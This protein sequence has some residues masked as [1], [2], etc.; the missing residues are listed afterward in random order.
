[1]FVSVGPFD[2]ILENPSSFKPYSYM[3]GNLEFSTDKTH[4]DYDA[5]SKGFLQRLRETLPIMPEFKVPGN[6]IRIPSLYSAITPSQDDRTVLE[7]I[8]VWREI[9]YKGE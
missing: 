2:G 5:L 4:K 6:K 7:I 1:M 8:E 3:Q 9:R